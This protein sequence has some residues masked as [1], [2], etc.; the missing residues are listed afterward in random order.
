MELAKIKPIKPI[1]N[2]FNMIIW[3]LAIESKHISTE[4]KLPGSYYKLQFIVNY[5]DA[6]LSVEV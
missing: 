2:T 1:N 5:L 6:S 3:Y 4:Q